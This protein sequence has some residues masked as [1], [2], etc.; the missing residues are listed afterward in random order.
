MKLAMLVTV[1][2][3]VLLA[4]ACAEPVPL[5]QQELWNRSDAVV[6][7][8][9]VR[10]T[11]TEHTSYQGTPVFIAE[12]RIRQSQK[13]NLSVGSSM[14]W[15][16]ATTESAPGENGSSLVYPGDIGRIYL[17]K[18][19]DGTYDTWNDAGAEWI[20]KQELANKGLPRKIGDTVHLDERG[21][22]RPHRTTMGKSKYHCC[23]RGSRSWRGHRK[24]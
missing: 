1:A 21:R 5:T 13:G 18:S 10:L 6:V 2:H 15:H 22:C 19:T 17:K 23:C 24:N 14:I 11:R 9:V 12:L 7:A 4:C 8:Q 20:V 3:F 16:V